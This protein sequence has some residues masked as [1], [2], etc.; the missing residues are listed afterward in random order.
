MSGSK[1]LE[2]LLA[3]E[4]W[5]NLRVLDAMRSC[6]TLPDRAMILVAHMAASQHVWISRITNQT[7]TMAVFPVLS[8][9]DCE[10][11]FR[12]HHTQ[13]MAWAKDTETLQRIV[14]Y[15]TTTGSSFENTVEELIAHLCLHA[16]YHRGQINQLIKPIATTTHD[17]DYIQYLRTK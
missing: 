17:V 12:K 1:L 14:A 4:L 11:L 3:H 9:D 7:H 8:I 6:D 5:G 10:A 15:R 16:Q 2:Q 13:L